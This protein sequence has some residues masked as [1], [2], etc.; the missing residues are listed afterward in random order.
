[1]KTYN[2]PI[3]G[4]HCAS[5]AVRIQQQL[6][7]HPGVKEV[8]VN[9]ALQQA[10]V[11]ADDNVD[12]HALHK[13]VEQ[14]GYQVPSHSASQ[15]K[16]TGMGGHDHGAIPFARERKQ[17][18]RRAL[19]SGILALPVFLSAMGF[20]PL[21]S[22]ILPWFEGILASMAVLGTGF[23][24]HKVA[25]QQARRF[26]AGMDTLI[27]LGTL[28]SLASSWWAV[29]MET[30]R[31]FETAAII[32][33]FILLG[34]ALEA[35]SKGKAGEA[36]QGLLSLGAKQA[37]LIESDGSIRDIPP[38][39]IRV[40]DHLLVKP[41]EKIPSDAV[42]RSG[43]SDVDESALTGESVP[44]TKQIG[45]M[46]FAATINQDGSLTLEV[47]KPAGETVMARIIK[48]MQDAQMKRAPIQAL[49]DRV[50]AIFVPVVLGLAF[51]TFIVWFLITK[52][53]ATS[54]L[55]AIAVL[56]IA[57]PCALGLAT[58]TAILVGTGHGARKGILIKSGEALER[59]RNISKVFFDKTGTLTQGKPAVV[60]L[61]AIRGSDFELL[62][63]AASLAHL[64]SHPLSLALAS[65]AQKEKISLLP[66]DDFLSV[67][68]K[69]VQGK[70]QN[71]LYRLGQRAWME[72]VGIPFPPALEETVST[73]H[74]EGCTVLVFAKNQ[75]VIGLFALR[76][77]VRETAIQAVQELHARHI[78]TAMITGDKKEVAE[79]IA[80][81]LGM[82]DI[83]AQVF[84]EQKLH[85]VKQTQAL[86]KYVAFVGDG[87]N[88]APALTQA[89]LGIAMGSGTDIALEAGQMVIIG[90]DPLK[91]PQAIVLARRTYRIIKQNL[92]WAFLYNVL[93]IP[94]AALGF[95]TP[96]IASAAMAFSSVSVVLNSLRLRK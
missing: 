38:E 2:F 57:C 46:V 75:E 92:F 59:A 17:A 24:F 34:K 60:H 33:F 49:A 71:N 67:T 47:T 41:G 45:D 91:V 73:W 96:I 61:Q 27:S 85:L 83:F 20:L 69:G 70:I 19:L 76:D 12:I 77:Q 30:H 74:K 7:K 31:Y 55:P 36:L 72:G 15:E 9:Y 44:A 93:A 82:T 88:D 86:G 29:F 62:Q 16:H 10:Q 1:M 21:S 78:E 81:P 65:R 53:M 26:T 3:E 6:S 56:V 8:N 64:S 18:D 13:I 50:S 32:T 23:I 11:H 35:R 68:A 94:F 14:E 87:I 89:D 40:G 54:L 79:A 42:V 4:M 80:R 84:P 95:L 43:I 51:V 58:P 37:H 48:L 28:V 39:Q 52:D 63:H 25:F 66:V 22:T 5:C 90:S